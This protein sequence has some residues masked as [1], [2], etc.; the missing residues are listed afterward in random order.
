MGFGKKKSKPAPAQAAPV[1]TVVESKNYDA[2]Q[3][4][5]NANAQARVEENSSAT[6]LQ[7]KDDEEL[8]RK[9]AAATGLA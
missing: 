5:Q 4:A 8:K 9:Q 7:T 3:A 2:T 1:P 6:L